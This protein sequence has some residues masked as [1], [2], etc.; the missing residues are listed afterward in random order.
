MSVAENYDY[1][2]VGSGAAGSVLAA[3]LAAANHS[4]CVVEAGGND[5]SPMIRIPAGFVKNLTKPDHMWQFNSVP[6]ENTGN[7]SVSLPQGKVLGGSTSING[8]IYNRGQAYDYDHWS[9]LGNAGWSYS[10]VLPYFRK[11]ETRLAEESQYRGSHGPLRISDP[12]QSHPLCDA[13]IESVAKLTGAPTDNDY[14]GATQR[15]VGY[16]QRFIHEGSR[17]TTAGAF[18][19]PAVENYNISL[20]L[21]T[22]ALRVVVEKNKATG[23]E[24]EH[25]GKRETLQAKKE[26]LLCAGTVNTARLL[27]HS[28]I[29]DGEHLRSL[30]IPVVHHLPGVGENLQDHYFVRL[31]ARLKRGVSTLNS[32]ARGWRL[33]LQIARWYMGK[34]SILGWSP[35]IAYAFLNSQDQSSET[36]LPDLQFVFSHGSYRPGRVY[37]LDTFPA[38]TCGLTQQRPESKGY[39]RITSAD[40]YKSPDVQPNYLKEEIDQRVTVRGIK[41]A[42]SILQGESFSQWFEREEVPGENIVSDQ[43]LLEHARNTGNTG[44]HLVGSC[45]MGPAVDPMAVVDPKLRVHGLQQLRV[46]DASVMP[47]VTSSNTCAPTI[48]I[49]EKGADLVLGSLV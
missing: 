19:K 13:F 6:G 35:S 25:N 17:E 10:E 1:I 23:L 26:L 22:R 40:P 3:R 8:L 36:E 43:E 39:V 44:Y 21:Q 28:G 49:A 24:V 30:D 15:G 27:Q 31:A 5:N 45:K 20:R 46:I 47:R 9:A 38:V 37:E 4:V 16:Y 32:Q 33:G 34:P 11:S 41:M 2:I 7:R 12:D 14:N 18:L 42:R 29:G 48:M